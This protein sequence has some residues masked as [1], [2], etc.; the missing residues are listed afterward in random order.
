MQTRQLTIAIWLATC[1]L[2]LFEA[3]MCA[4]SASTKAFVLNY[5]R[6]RGEFDAQLKDSGMF[7]ELIPQSA[8]REKL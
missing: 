8:K 4:K 2:F 7:D 1:G 6:S 5:K 3:S